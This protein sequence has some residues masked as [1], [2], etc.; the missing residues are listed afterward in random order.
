MSRLDGKLSNRRLE[1]AACNVDVVSTLVLKTSG[2]SSVFFRPE[3][4]RLA[5]PENSPRRCKVAAVHFHGGT[6][7]PQSFIVFDCEGLRMLIAQLNELHLKRPGGVAY[8]DY[9]ERPCF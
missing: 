5:A 6:I 2:A 4:V 8:G 7:D 9:V 1:T 3:A